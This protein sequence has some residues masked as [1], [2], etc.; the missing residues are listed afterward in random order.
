MKKYLLFSTLFLS[1][2][3]YAQKDYDDLKLENTTLKTENEYLRKALNINKPI[4]EVEK[5]NLLFSITDIQGNAEDSN[6][7]ITFLAE[8]KAEY[9]SLYLKDFSI[10][11]LEGNEYKV[12]FLKSSYVHPELA[13][14]VPLKLTF[15]FKDVESKPQFLK[16]L[17]FKVTSKGKKYATGGFNS[18]FEFHD[19]KVVWN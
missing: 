13:Q 5:D 11:D 10:I 2:N 12:D 19:L 6:I 16:N 17:K 9:F 8:T 1:L 3:V 18:N 15:L 7:Q 14:N 4:V